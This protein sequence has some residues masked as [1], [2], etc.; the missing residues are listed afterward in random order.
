MLKKTYKISVLFLVTLLA[1]VFGSCEKNLGPPS[2]SFVEGG[3]FLS[4]DTTLM[5]GDTINVGVVIEWNGA[6]RLTTLDVSVSD[7]LLSSYVIDEERGEYSFKLMK[8]ASEE[9]VWEFAV[10]DSKG[11]TAKVDITLFKD[12]NSIYGGVER[13]SGIKLGAQVNPTI[14]G[15][16]SLK[17]P[18]LYDVNSAFLQ[19]SEIDL[20]LYFDETDG[21]VLASP[22]A[23]IPQGI[24]GGNNPVDTWET[25]IT[26]LYMK[27]DYTAQEFENFFHDGFLV[28]KF[29]PLEAKR[30]AKNL[31]AGDVYLFK[32]QTGRIGGFSV[33]TVEE[34]PDGGIEFNLLLQEK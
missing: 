25:K 14:P 29:D 27:S 9:E 3:G 15:F 30:K 22:G 26:T 4:H 1:L 6:N 33:V 16:L 34:S 31:A 19:Q 20:V 23:N 7:D 17:G 24:F 5:V 8:S 12:P 10:Y 11:N 28:Q 2:I 13:Y 18:T 21:C 32:T